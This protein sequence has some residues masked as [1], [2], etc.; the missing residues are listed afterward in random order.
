MSRSVKRASLKVVK[1]RIDAK[2]SQPTITT[3]VACPEPF[4]RAI[5]ITQRSVNSRDAIRRDV[6]CVSVNSFKQRV[7]Y[8]FSSQRVRARE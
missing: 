6:F 8:S 5:L 1:N 7:A 2:P 3:I 4:E